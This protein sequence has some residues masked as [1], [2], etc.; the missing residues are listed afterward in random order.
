[1]IN[2]QAA[3]SSQALTSVAATLLHS[4]WQATV[5]AGLLWVALRLVP[6]KRVNLR[7][8][9]TLAAMLAVVIVA[10]VTFKVCEMS[11][12]AALVANGT[13]GAIVMHAE[14]DYRET[15][16]G[17]AAVS[18][19]PWDRGAAPAG[20]HV[21][22]TV[23]AG[24]Y[25]PAAGKI[26]NSPIWATCLVIVWMAGAVLTLMR[27]ALSLRGAAECRRLAQPVAG[28]GIEEVVQELR[29]K[30]GIG[31]AVAVAI[32]GKV[33]SPAVIGIIV[34]IILLPPA[35][36]TG[37]PVEQLRA[38]LAHELAH[39][40]RCDWLVNVLQ[41]LVES[42]GFFNPAV[43]WIS[44]QIRVEREASCD[45]V[46]AK[47]IGAPSNMAR[48]LVD[49]CHRVKDAPL[50]AALALA[51]EKHST[52][53]D[54]VRRLAMPGHRPAVRLP[55]HT[56]TILILAATLALAILAKGTSLAVEVAAQMLTPEQRV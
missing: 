22:D 25:S 39:V 21:K 12:A 46:A 50:T 29:S 32:C 52:L 13:S 16:A 15:A 27:V 17:G 34:P 31:R 11:S 19:P 9:L 48:A 18:Q 51:G 7:Y 55:W 5:L 26:D 10:L 47:V 3:I 14:N 1:M 36:L 20:N 54:R 24:A 33:T 42:L 37:V 28:Q 38:I 8:S 56:F 30:L 53:S 49:W 4:L 23:P 2:L 35:A 43:W 44:R 41:M 40:R 45:A 6:A